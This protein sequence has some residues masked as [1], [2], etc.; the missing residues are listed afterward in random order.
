[1]SATEPVHAALAAELRRAGTGLVF[2]V[3]GGGPNLELIGACE[4]VGLRFVLAHT[5]TAAAIMASTSAEL[6]GAP[7]A[8]LATR[9]PGAASMVNGI[10]HARLDR[11]PLIAVTDVVSAADR[12]RISHQLLDQRTLLGAVAKASCTLGRDAS[13]HVAEVVACATTA[14]WGPI[15]VDSDPGAASDTRSLPAGSVSAPP[16]GAVAHARR[17][18]TRARRP[19][20]LAGVGARGAERDL[21]RYSAAHQIPVLASYKAKGVIDEADELSAGLLTGATIEAPILA[22]AD[23]ILAVGL[24]PVEL[25][26]AP[27]PYGA[28]VIALGPWLSRDTYF[29]PAVELAG[30][31]G[32]L[33][34]ELSGLTDGG[35]W[36]Q[37]IPAY[38]RASREALLGSGGGG[39]LSPPDVILA[40]RA[41]F[42]R[43]AVA[44]VDAGA[45]MLPAMELWDVPGPRHALISSGLATMG[46]ALPAAIAAALTE[47]SRPVVC[48]TGDGGLGMCLAELETVARLELN[49]TVV[50]LDDS[51]LSLIELKQQR[52]QG[53]VGAVAYREVDFARIARAVGLRA[54]RVEDAS[55]LEDL[56]EREANRPGPS[57]IDAV[58]DPGAYRPIMAAIRGGSRAAPLGQPTPS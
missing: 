38:R 52:G 8:S 5:E 48:L 30:D 50:V 14:P 31:V 27:W 2:G 11:C 6:T 35:G 39:G 40:A 51:R 10:A 17:L 43:V 20:L 28:P 18:L 15:H 53:G 26:P 47:P 12:D 45:H 57:L 23:V 34:E 37:S 33:L 7:G 9:G 3:P 32:E 22:A 42:P 44:T 58:I 54:D 1:M 21:A 13:D 56:L 19:L 29:R 36:G 41:A 49:L 4:D 24:D 16:A 46:F 25:I 55:S